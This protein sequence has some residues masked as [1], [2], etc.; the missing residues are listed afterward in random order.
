VAYF[1]KRGG[2]REEKRKSKRERERE[3]GKKKALD[4]QALIALPAR[5]HLGISRV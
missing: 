3:K 4:Q 1:T 5:P 2:K